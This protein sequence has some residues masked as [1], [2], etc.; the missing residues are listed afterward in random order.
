MQKAGNILQKHVS[1]VL[2][3]DIRL[4]ITSVT[5]LT[6]ESRRT[7]QSAHSAFGGRSVNAIRKRKT[8]R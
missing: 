1:C 5:V 2:C 6:V 3:F 4:E 8:F 7:V